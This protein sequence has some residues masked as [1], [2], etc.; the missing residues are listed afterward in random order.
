MREILFKAKRADNKKWVQGYLM[1]EDYINVPFN[2][3]SVGMR[4]DEPIEI[5]PETICQ[6][7]GFNDK[8]RK[9]IFENDIVKIS[10]KVNDGILAVVKFGE[11]NSPFRSD[12]LGVHLG[13]YLDFQ[14][15]N[16]VLRKDF[17]YWCKNEYI[18]VI[19]NIYDNPELLEVQE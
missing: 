18:E 2:D 3:D 5:L 19:G 16:D 9:E 6:Y 10:N 13:F 11:Y 8:K 14:E 15:K 1:D 7:T 12:N 4:E 17:L